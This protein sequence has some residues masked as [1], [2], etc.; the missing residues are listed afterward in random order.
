MWIYLLQV[1]CSGSIVF[2]EAILEATAIVPRG[3][4][5]WTLGVVNIKNSETEDGSPAISPLHSSEKR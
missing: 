1:D 3:L 5:K 2:R 4:R